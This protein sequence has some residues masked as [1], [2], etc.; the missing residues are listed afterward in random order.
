MDAVEGGSGIINGIGANRVGTGRRFSRA[1]DGVIKQQAAAP[2]ASECQVSP[3][4]ANQDDGHAGIARQFLGQFRDNIVQ[5][6]AVGRKRV[7]ARDL[8]SAGL[9]QEIADG[10]LALDDLRNRL[11]QVKVTTVIAAEEGRPFVIGEGF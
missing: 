2:C 7:E 4:P 10:V 5:W 6:D 1:T 11:A 9:D 3:R 8:A